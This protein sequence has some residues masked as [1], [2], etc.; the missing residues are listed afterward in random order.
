M[1]LLLLIYQRKQILAILGG[2]TQLTPLPDGRK[3]TPIQQCSD[4]DCSFASGADCRW[5]SDRVDDSKNENIWFLA[6]GQPD[7]TVWNTA[8]SS[9]TLPDEP[10]AII[11]IGGGIPA[12]PIYSD[13]ITVLTG[14]ESTVT[15]DY[16]MTKSASLKVCAVSADANHKQLYCTSAITQ[17]SPGPPSPGPMV[18]TITGPIKQAFQVCNSEAKSFLKENN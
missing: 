8:T 13:P 3:T 7:P 12:N 18:A 15:F 16:W 4:L 11:P 14:Q 6:T 10:Y 2:T 9:S 17:G 1:A 5:G